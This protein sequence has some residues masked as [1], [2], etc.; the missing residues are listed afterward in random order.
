LYNSILHGQ[1]LTADGV[2]AARA[3]VAVQ[4]HLLNIPKTQLSEEVMPFDVFVLHDEI[5]FSVFLDQECHQ[6]ITAVIE[7]LAKDDREIT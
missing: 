6:L 3:F 1:Q 7:Y 2:D 5:L 4:A